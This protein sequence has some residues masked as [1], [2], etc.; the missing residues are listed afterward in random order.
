MSQAARP[1]TIDDL[2][3]G[4]KFPYYVPLWE[5]ALEQSAEQS[6]QKKHVDM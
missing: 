4:A 5:V 3:P 2:T 1:Q 6:S